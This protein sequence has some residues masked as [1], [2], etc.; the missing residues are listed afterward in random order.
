MALKQTYLSMKSKLPADSEAVLVMRGRGNDELAPSKE[1]LEDFS[2]E[3]KHYAT[4]SGFES[5]IHY[6]WEKSHYAERFR[7]QVT[8]NAKAMKRLRELSERAR[9]HDV[10]LICYEGDDKPCHRK[11]LLEIADEALD[12]EVDPSPFVPTANASK[13]EDKQRQETLPLFERIT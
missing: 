1:L 2:E 7:K 10:Y 3:K 8:Q 12:A 9:D 4:D 6:A 11:L 13:A 5:A